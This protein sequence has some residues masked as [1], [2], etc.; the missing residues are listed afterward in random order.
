MER[1]RDSL[2]HY[3]LTFR[4]QPPPTP[5]IPGLLESFR[6]DRELSLTVANPTPETETLLAAL[7]PESLEPVEMTL[8]DAFVGATW[9]SAE[10]E[11][12]SCASRNGHESADLE[13]T[14]GKL[15]VGLAGRHCLSPWHF[16]RD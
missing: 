3:V 6:T 9:A 11:P 12:F 14:A 1:F 16:G 13:G 15:E 4:D 8:E 10:R 7:Q 5:D 2:R